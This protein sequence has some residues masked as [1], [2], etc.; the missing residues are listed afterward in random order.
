MNGPRRVTAVPHPIRLRSRRD[1]A[2]NCWSH[3]FAELFSPARIT[4]APCIAPWL[5]LCRRAR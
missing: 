5:L 4:V 2:Y 1:Q 3:H